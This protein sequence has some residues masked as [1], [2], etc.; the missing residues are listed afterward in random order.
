MTLAHWVAYWLTHED[1]QRLRALLTEFHTHQQL[2]AERW[3]DVDFLET[4]SRSV[5]QG[6]IHVVRGQYFASLD[7]ALERIREQERKAVA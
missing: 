2:M 3:T 5:E 7:N 4:V 1:G 6:S